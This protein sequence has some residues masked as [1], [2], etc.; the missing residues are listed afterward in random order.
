M[1]LEYNKKYFQMSFRFDKNKPEDFGLT[2]SAYNSNIFIDKSDN[3]EWVNRELYDFGWGNEY[4]FM[5]LP[6]LDF[7]E[8][9][10]LLENSLLKENKYGAAYIL[11]NEYPDNLLNNLLGILNNPDISIKKSTKEI[12]KI[13]KLDSIK[14]RSE[15]VGK[16]FAEIEKD[17]EN[18]KFVCKKVKEILKE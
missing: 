13:L 8:L 5:K 3:S 16:S 15:I 17:F 11:E 4:G 14:N 10:N 7:F 6:K 2:Q 1:E 12:Y 18:W 9:W